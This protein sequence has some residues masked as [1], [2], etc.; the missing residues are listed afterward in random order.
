MFNV[1]KRSTPSISS[2]GLN[3]KSPEFSGSNRKSMGVGIEF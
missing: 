2:F 3:Y 1:N